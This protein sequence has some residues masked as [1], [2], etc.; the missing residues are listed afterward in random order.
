VAEEADGY[1]GYSPGMMRT[2]V[3]PSEIDQ[4]RREP[5][6]GEEQSPSTKQGFLDFSGEFSARGGNAA[7]QLLKQDLKHQEDA[8]K[9]R[10]RTNKA[11]L[12]SLL[13]RQT[14]FNNPCNQEVPDNEMD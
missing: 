7:R 4:L 1:Y 9:F 6:G 8:L 3:G 14:N 11:V 5:Y 10:E 2:S 12:A 13:G